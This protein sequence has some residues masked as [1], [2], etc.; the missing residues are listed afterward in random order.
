MVFFMP[1]NRSAIE[2]YTTTL[3]AIALQALTDVYLEFKYDLYWYFDR[4]AD[5]KT[6]WIVLGLYPQVNLIFLNFFPYRKSFLKKVIYIF[7]WTVFALNFELILV[8][9][10][11]FVYD[12]WRIWFSVPIYPLLYLI[13]YWN[14][15]FTKRL[16]EK[17]K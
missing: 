12:E 5:L 17:N 14:Q 16:V 13:L 6:L 11:I 9:I 7:W 8:K 1:K 4:G 3:F 15:M 10:N 2:M